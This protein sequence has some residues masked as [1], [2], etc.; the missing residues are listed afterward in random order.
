MLG[1]FL[2]KA[3]ARKEATL[4]VLYKPYRPLDHHPELVQQIESLIQQGDFEKANNVSIELIDLALQGLHYYQVYPS[5]IRLI[6]Y[7]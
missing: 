7:I 5:I 3:E 1:Q 2:F 4:K 6:L